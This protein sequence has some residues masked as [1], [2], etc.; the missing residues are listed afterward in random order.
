MRFIL[1][2]DST[3]ARVCIALPQCFWSPFFYDPRAPVCHTSLA[4]SHGMPDVLN[5][6]F[7]WIFDSCGVLIGFSPT[8]KSILNLRLSLTGCLMFLSS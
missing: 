3:L 8:V 7:S 6:A 4:L 1:W 5:P 2:K